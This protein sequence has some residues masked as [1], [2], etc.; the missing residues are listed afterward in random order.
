MLR[1]HRVFDYQG[2]MKAKHHDK[3]I[4]KYQVRSDHQELVK[5]AVLDKLFTSLEQSTFV[6]KPKIL[7]VVTLEI[8]KVCDLCKVE[9]SLPQYYNYFK[10][11]H[12]C[13]QCGD[14]RDE[15]KKTIE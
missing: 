1:R 5:T 14:K 9:L 3:P 8:G 4:L 11:Q 2:S 12:L 15:T 10:K 7:N 13:I 6:V